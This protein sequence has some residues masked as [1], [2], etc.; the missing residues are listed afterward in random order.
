[1]KRTWSKTGVWLIAALLAAAGAHADALPPVQHSG[2]ISYL[3]GGVG[4]E[5]IQAIKAAAAQY[6]LQMTFFS[7]IDGRDSYNAPDEVTILKADGAPVLDLKPDGP[8]LLV[9]LPPGKYR[10]TAGSAAA[11]KTLSVELGRGAHKRLVFQV[12]DPGQDQK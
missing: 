12:N 11:S 8:F 2:N 6:T 4:E 1:M 3:S 10:I 5:E 7:R 9:D